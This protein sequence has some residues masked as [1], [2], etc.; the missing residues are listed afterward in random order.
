MTGVIAMLNKESY[1]ARVSNATV[2]PP[3]PDGIPKESTQVAEL[4]VEAQD[5]QEVLLE[6]MEDE[7]VGKVLLTVKRL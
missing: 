1:P 6:V 4:T 7:G 5:A 3:S 2:S